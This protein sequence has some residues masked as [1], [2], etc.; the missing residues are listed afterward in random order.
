MM[1]FP[2]KAAWRSEIYD[3]WKHINASSCWF[4]THSHM[5]KEGN[6]ITDLWSSPWWPIGVNALEWNAIV[7]EISAACRCLNIYVYIHSIYKQHIK[8]INIEIILVGLLIVMFDPI[9]SQFPMVIYKSTN[10]GFHFILSKT[11]YL[12]MTFTINDFWLHVE[13]GQFLTYSL[14]TTEKGHQCHS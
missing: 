9:I 10:L 14:L 2:L 3:R 13:C 12:N 8:H 1:R 4:L 5:T 11:P 7:Q 6:C